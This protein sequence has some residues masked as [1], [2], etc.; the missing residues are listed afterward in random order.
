MTEQSTKS[1]LDDLDTRQDAALLQ[2]DELNERLERL[3]KQ[4][5]VGLRVIE[6]GDDGTVAADHVPTMDGPGQESVQL[7]N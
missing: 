2:L 6:P 1:L 7:T 3:L 4:H 5:S